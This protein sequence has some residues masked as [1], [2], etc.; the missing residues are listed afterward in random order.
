MDKDITLLLHYSHIMKMNCF[1]TFQVLPGGHKEGKIIDHKAC[2]KDTFYLDIDNETFQRQIGRIM[3]S[4]I[5][6]STLMHGVL[7]IY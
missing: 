5:N 2:W 6:K 1:I 3:N 7:L 4:I